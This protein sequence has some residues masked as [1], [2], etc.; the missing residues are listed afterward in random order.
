MITTEDFR[1]IE[2]ND[3]SEGDMRAIARQ[4]ARA[5]LRTLENLPEETRT[6]WD[7]QRIAELREFIDELA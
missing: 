3:A 2:T 1:T 4:E 5:E 7:N 6:D